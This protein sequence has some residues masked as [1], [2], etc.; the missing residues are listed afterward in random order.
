MLCQ[1]IK[2]IIELAILV[3]FLAGCSE[4]FAEYYPTYDAAAKKGAIQRGWIP[5]SVP[6]TATEICEQHDLDTNEV[7][8][9]FSLPPVEKDRIADGLNKLTHDEILK[10]KLRFPSSVDWWFEDLIQQSPANDNA[11]NAEIYIVKRESYK[12]A[13]LA[14]DRVS[15]RIY[16]WNTY[17]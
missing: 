8:L 4:R 17:E 13:Y 16:Y 9:R 10:M 15:S 7:W 6:K 5:A 11:L 12:I 2:R 14:V 1:I 3:A